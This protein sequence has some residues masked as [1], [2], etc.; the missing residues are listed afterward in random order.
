[1][2]WHDSLSVASRV[3]NE[4]VVI[5][6]TKDGGVYGLHASNGIESDCF[7][8]VQISLVEKAHVSATFSCQIVKKVDGKLKPFNRVLRIPGWRATE[9]GRKLLSLVDPP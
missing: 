1:L 4:F 2:E 8:L 3:E 5:V 6:E 9:G 7:Y